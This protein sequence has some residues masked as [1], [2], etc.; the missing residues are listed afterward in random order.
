QAAFDTK[1]GTS[2]R[3]VA[4][5]G[6]V[7][8]LAEGRADGRIGS[9]HVDDPYRFQTNNVIVQC[10]CCAA[11][12]DSGGDAATPEGIGRGERSAQNRS[13]RH[14]SKIIGVDQTILHG[15]AATD[16]EYAPERNRLIAV[17]HTVKGE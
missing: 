12:V 3:Y 8:A 5:S 4:G 14:S 15:G 17:V 2:E 7:C 6:S 13:C 11:V 10:D 9:I 1:Y 16:R